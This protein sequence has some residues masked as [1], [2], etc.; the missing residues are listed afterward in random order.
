MVQANIGNH[1]L[2]IIHHNLPFYQ[3]VEKKKK[4]EGK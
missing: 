2:A 4:R 1:D 3:T